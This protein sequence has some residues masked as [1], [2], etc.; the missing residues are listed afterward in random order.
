ME[1][2]GLE[3]WLE[4]FLQNPLDDSQA[5]V[6]LVPGSPLL[7]SVLL[8]LLNTHGAYKLTQEHTSA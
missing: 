4:G 3:A 7:S 2:Q 8:G 6:T 5:S 1:K